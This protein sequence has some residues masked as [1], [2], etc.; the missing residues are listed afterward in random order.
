MPGYGEI[1]RVPD[2]IA[3]FIYRHVVANP[4]SFRFELSN[5]IAGTTKGAETIGLRVN[6]IYDGKAGT[7]QDAVRMAFNTVLNETKC[8]DTAMLHQPKTSP[9]EALALILDHERAKGGDLAVQQMQST[10][11]TIAAKIRDPKNKRIL[12]LGHCK[13][14]GD[15][16]GCVVGLKSAIE[17]MD[18]TR[19]I[20]MAVDD[21]IPGLFR[22]K[23]P[24]VDE[25]KRPKDPTK[26]RSL[27]KEI[28]QLK[29][30]EQSE[31][32]KNRLA[33][34]EQ[35]LAEMKDASRLLNPRATYDLIITMD[36]PTPK[37]FTG[38]FKRY[39]DKAKDAIY[40][41]HHPFR[42]NE[43]DNAAEETGLDIQQALGRNLV[44]VADSVAAAAQ[45]VGILGS[46]LVPEFTEIA[47]GKKSC[48]VYETQEQQDDVDQYAAGL[49]T[50][51]S[52]DTG[53]F[54]RT[55]NLTPQ[56][57]AKPVQNRPNFNPEGMAKW[58]M[59][60]TDG[61]IDK[62]WLRENI[63]YDIPDKTLKDEAQSS[64]R[65]AML[66]YALQGKKVY[67]EISLGIVQVD[68]DQMNEVWQTAREVDP[69]V[70]FL[71]VQNAF[72]Y[73]EVM[74]A[75]R[76]DPEKQGGSSR[77]RRSPRGASGDQ[78]LRVRTKES[79]T[80][81]FDNAR[82]AV[83]ICQDK[84]K[85]QLDE[86]VQT[87]TQ[88]GLRMSFRSADGTDYA[89]VLASLFS[90]GGHGAA[91]GGRVDLPE[92]TLDTR[93][94]VKINGTPERDPATILQT[95]RKNI[96][97]MKNESIPQQDKTKNLTPVSVVTDA[98]NGKTSA[99]WLEALTTEI[100]K[101]P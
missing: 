86:K 70:T 74:S 17:L 13:P 30:E 77:S 67:P 96:A 100:R 29:K 20:D 32:V 101:A 92:V 73:S 78:P 38:N 91:A 69:E 71:D 98:T 25:I 58:M 99:E 83:L 47:N 80:G 4:D 62:K 65:D 56:D 44:W 5:V 95:L 7:T 85:G 94:G 57:M 76:G 21:K 11:D 8:K 12:L 35:E 68:Y 36:V 97:V 42:Y 59:G 37:R 61:R 46:R 26:I 50:G 24:G 23:V 87:A 18:P 81:K 63:T 54:T 64:A 89:E 84:K 66:E 40:I 34:L 6:L 60:L 31:S 16:L 88:N 9:E 2:E 1:G 28:R 39:F 45:M 3:R 53:S 55:A 75:L 14:D 43:W 51:M 79:Y 93:L 41:D 27:Q 22:N 90:G 49:V 48:E 52:T 15:T 33:M 82:I 19:K 72:K 10:I